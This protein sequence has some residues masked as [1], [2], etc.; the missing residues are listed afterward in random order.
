MHRL[1]PSWRRCCC[2]THFPKQLL[3]KPSCPN[4]CRVCSRKRSHLPTP[5]VVCFISIARV[6]TCQR[7]NHDGELVEALVEL[8]N[9]VQSPR[10]K[11]RV[12][13]QLAHHATD[14][15]DLQRAEVCYQEVLERDPTDVVAMHAL[16][17]LLQ[18]R[19][20]TKQAIELLRTAVEA[21]LTIGGEPSA[22][23]PSTMA[24]LS[25]RKLG[26]GDTSAPVGAQAAAL[27][28]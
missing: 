7:R 23:L 1:R 20:D 19:G 24:M 5:Q 10:N 16:A 11:L 8:L 12:L 27:L 14:A 17:R 9:R 22:A 6:L 18:Q 28:A 2:P 13:K 21:A 3:A 15:G 26:L 4:C 25:P